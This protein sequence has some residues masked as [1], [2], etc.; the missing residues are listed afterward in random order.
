MPGRL[1]DV[2]LWLSVGGLLIAGGW[3]AWAGG[4]NV[5]DVASKLWSSWTGA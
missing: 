5:L 1:W 3:G 4:R 2:L